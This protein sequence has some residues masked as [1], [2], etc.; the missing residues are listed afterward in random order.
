MIAIS[1]SIP[2]RR[3]VRLHRHQ[4]HETTKKQVDRFHPDGYPTLWLASP[5]E[6]HALAVF[7]KHYNAFL[8]TL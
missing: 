5:S 8:N 3:T 2:A 7:A 6:A 4:L 1:V